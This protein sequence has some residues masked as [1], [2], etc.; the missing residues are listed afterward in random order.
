MMAAKGL[1][2]LIEEIGELQ[3]VAGKKLACYYTDEHPDGK[4]SL[5]TRMENEIADVMA[6][7]AFVTDRF[8]LSAERIAKRSMTKLEQY[9]DW[10]KQ[11]DITDGVNDEEH[12]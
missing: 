1:A 5:K 7:C 12:F 10:D 9:Q 2:K 4:G 3:Q 6:C 8:C 11:S